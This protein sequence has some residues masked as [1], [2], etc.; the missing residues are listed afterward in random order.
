MEAHDIT[1]INMD[2]MTD[3]LEERGIT[4]EDVQLTIAA[5]ENT[6]TKL[7]RT[8]DENRFLAKSR[9]ENLNVYVEYTLEDN[10]I[11]LYTAFAH[12]VMLISEDEA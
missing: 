8:D 1:I 9:L 3:L 4:L 10:G 12:R 6:G 11:R 2:E 5:G 7:Y